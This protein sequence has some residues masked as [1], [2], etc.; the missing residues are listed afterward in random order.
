MQHR[1]PPWPS[2]K[3][4]RI[5]QILV[6][7]GESYGLD[8]VR[9]SEGSLKRGTIYV[10]LDR[11]EKKGFVESRKEPPPSRQGGM[12]RRMYR[13]TGLGERALQ[14]WESWRLEGTQLVGG[15]A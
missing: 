5:L 12:P 7:N 3:E 6:T 1:A 9:R 4:A 10:A 11:M 15:E 8:L 14:M 2:G 13:V